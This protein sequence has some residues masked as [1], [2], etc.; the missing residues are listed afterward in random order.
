M[1]G[2]ERLRVRVCVFGGVRSAVEQQHGAV[3]V[4]EVAAKKTLSRND[5]G[6]KINFK[7][8]KRPLCL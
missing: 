4:E 5:V 6:S 3:R 1:K 8:G 7:M 2:R